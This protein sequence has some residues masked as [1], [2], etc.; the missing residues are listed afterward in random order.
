[1]RVVSVCHPQP[2]VLLLKCGAKAAAAA[3]D[4][5]A[6]L[7]HTEAKVVRMDLLLAQ[8]VAKIGFYVDVYVIAVAQLA[9]YALA[10]W[11]SLPKFVSAMAV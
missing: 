1:M 7:G 5:V 10:Q 3:A 6:E 9:P 11:D 4:V 8:L 2:L